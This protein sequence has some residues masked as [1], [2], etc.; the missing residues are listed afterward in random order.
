MGNNR[1]GANQRIKTI[2]S[3]K[4][5]DEA[6]LYSRAK[7]L[8]EIYR[9]VCWDTADRADIMR[10][11]VLYEYDYASGDL[12]AALMY[13]ENFAP[14]EKKERFAARVQSLFEVK[15]MIEIV[16]HAITKVHSFPIMGDMY[17]AIL[18]AYYL[19]SFP[20]TESEMMAQFSLERSSFYRRKKEAVIVFGLAMW[21]GSIEEFRSILTQDDGSGQQLSFGTWM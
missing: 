3:S 16:E 5:L 10:E 20:L 9:D 2:I 11:E 13:L 15:W 1:T 14:D 12:D 7:L 4:A 21:G 19:S 18:T 8:L 17:C 6:K